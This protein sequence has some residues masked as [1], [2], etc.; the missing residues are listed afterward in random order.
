MQFVA[1]TDLNK[2]AITGKSTSLD[3][4][5]SYAEY[6]FRKHL[7][8]ALND[9]ITFSLRDAIEERG[10]KIH[11]IESRV[12]EFSSI[13]QKCHEKEIDNPLSELHDISGARVI[14]LFRSD[15]DRIGNIITEVFDII[16]VDDKIT[17]SQDSFGYMSVHYICKLKDDFSGPRYKRVKG[18][19]FE[20]QVRTL[21]MH[22]WSVMSHYLDYKGDWDVPAHLKKALNALSGLFYVADS[23]F[24]QFVKESTA[25]KRSAQE[26]ENIN[27][28]NEEINLDT[29][30]AYLRSKFNDRKPSEPK[31]VSELV[32]EL[33]SSGFNKISDFSMLIDT[34]DQ[35]V[36][37]Y[38]KRYQGTKFLNEVGAARVALSISSEQYLEARKKLGRVKIRRDYSTFRKYLKKE[39]S[40]KT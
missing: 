11:D 26:N 7:F 39:D 13:V 10:I 37:E 5:A 17:K 29:L 14:C 2:N 23:E 12:K 20:I 8:N 4:E 36:I 35:A 9:E 38:E 19:K 27:E 22:A 34:A 30:T 16:D 3:V 32:E 21:S 33:K 25:S 24:E 18:I 6:V 31:H 40:E 1:M 15:I 28:Q